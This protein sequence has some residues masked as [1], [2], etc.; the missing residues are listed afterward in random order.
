[1]AESE[2]KPKQDNPQSSYK[3]WSKEMQSAEKRLR[4]FREQGNQTVDRYL[5]RIAGESYD[6]V[7]TGWNGAPGIQT[8]RLNFFHKNIKTISAMMMGRTPSIDVSREFQDPDDDIARVA[9][10]ILSRMLESDIAAS[11]SDEPTIMR[12]SLMDRLLPGL[13]VARVRYDFSAQTDNVVELNKHL[14][15][16]ADLQYIHWQDFRWGWARTWKEVPWIAFRNYLSRD[17][18]T[19]RFGK[20]KARNLEYSEQKVSHEDGTNDTG[21]GNAKGNV[22]KAQ[23][24]EI[25]HKK[26]KKVYWWSD[27]SDM[28]LDD[29]DDPL[30]LDGF[31]PMPRPLMANTTTTL[32]MPKADYIFVQDVYNEIDELGFR[33]ATLTRACKAVGVYDGDE[34][35]SIQR[36]FEE[37]IENQL[38][39]VQGWGTFADKGGIKGTVDWVPI[40]DVV[41]A[42]QVVNQQLQGAMD[43]LYELTG[44]SDILRGA[45]TDQYT[46]DGTQQMKAK[47]GSVEIQSFQDEWA[48]W[49]SE[50]E[51]LKAEVISKHFEP[52]TIIRQS[53]AE[54]LP[55]PDKP[56]VGEAIGLIKSPDVKWRVNIRPEDIA[57]ADF[58]QL[59]NERV[60][61]LNAMATYIQS[62]QAAVKSMGPGALPVLLE[63]VKFGMSGFKGADYME[64]ILDQ[65]IEQAKQE[66]KKPQ[67]DQNQG[68]QIKL[69]IEQ[70]KQQGAMQKAQFE[71]Q[72]VQAK[73]QADV[74]VQRNKLQGEISKIQ[75]DLQADLTLEEREARNRQVEIMRELEANLTEIQANMQAD[76]TVERAQAAYDIESQENDTDNKLQ[77]ISA[78]G[79]RNGGDS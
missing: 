72:K 43:L 74:M 20:E 48:R 5:G 79:T 11:G 46:S 7:E 45:K 62:T 32:F 33:S 50:L 9:S 59:R 15:E 14:N 64:G 29:K 4:T 8:F 42:L 23:V 67:Q 21:E 34:D 71:L 53:S 70:I 78:Q 12:Q 28:I 40:A 58:A 10:V 68:E 52:S 38:I 56:M 55:L 65:A 36:I 47:F 30:K 39:P 31:W 41:N 27:G 54:Y 69:Q 57:M 35:S 6:E 26:T 1:M 76:L 51:A 44:M 22:Q 63:F 13:G 2:D 49:V 37:G 18:A 61:F 16:S 66:A 3:F 17:E 75:A 24:W 19:K 77:I 60:E 25:W 73:A